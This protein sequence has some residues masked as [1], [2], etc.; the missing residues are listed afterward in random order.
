MPSPEQAA[1]LRSE[2]QRMTAKPNV[3]LYVV[4]ILT[5]GEKFFAPSVLS[6]EEIALAVAEGA[7]PVENMICNPGFV[8][9]HLDETRSVMYWGAPCRATAFR[10]KLTTV[11]K[12]G[13]LI[14]PPS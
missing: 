14:L 13:G 10:G 11:R 3:R 1:A 4:E 8:D 6:E 7:V 5:T 9:V 12:A 2:M